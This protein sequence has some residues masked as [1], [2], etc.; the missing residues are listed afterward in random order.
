MTNLHNAIYREDEREMI[1]MLQDLGVGMI[2]YS[3]QARGA[4]SKP[5]DVSSARKE[6][7]V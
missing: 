1:P 3:P 2:P 6:I 5:L 4:L 7:D